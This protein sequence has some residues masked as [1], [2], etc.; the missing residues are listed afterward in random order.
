MNDIVLHTKRSRIEPESGSNQTT[1]S[2]ALL[3]PI[4]NPLARPRAVAWTDIA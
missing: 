1:V 2:T 3:K 4:V